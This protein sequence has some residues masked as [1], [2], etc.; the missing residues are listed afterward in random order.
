MATRIEEATRAG[1]ARSRSKLLALLV[2]AGAQLM[3]VLDATIVNVALPHMQEG[4]GFT[5]TGLAWVI[6]AYTLTFGGL[7]LLGGRAGDVLGRRRVFIA[8]ILLFAGA[9]LAGG[10]ATSQAW[11]IVCRAAQGVGAAMA[12]PTALA[13]IT[14]TFA[15]GPE[16]N[17]AFGIYAAVAGAGA[18]IG[19]ILGGVLTDLLSWRWVLFVNVPIG[20]L[21]AVAAPY[22]L[23]ESERVA[24]RF[25]LPGALTATLGVSALVYGFIHSAEAGWGATGTVTAFVAAAVL[26]FSFVAIELRSSAPLVPMRL[27]ANRDRW[28]SYAIMLAVASSMFG[29]FFY[30][31]Q[32]V[33]EILGYSP[34]KAGLAFLP[35]SAAIIVAAQIASRLIARV[36]PRKLIAT[37]AVLTLVGLLWLSRINVDSGYLT[38]LLPAFIVQATGMGLMFVPVTLTAVSGVPRHE[39]GVASAMLNVSQQVGGAVG[40]SV[41]VTISA[42]ATRSAMASG[43]AHGAVGSAAEKAQLV[44][45]SL[46]HGWGEGILL[47]AVF[48]AVALAVALLALRPGGQ[49]NPDQNLGREVPDD[50]SDLERVPAMD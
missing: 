25:D 49:A 27:F 39:T 11:L 15:E 22:A 43:L 36:G 3:V 5:R 37:G 31:T 38:F 10:L 32:F 21:L 1:S 12:A 8:G 23:S 40:L 4:L 13:L 7:L 44:A 47:A 46:V 6:D 2:I 14:T 42:T 18:A 16:R 24:G 50:T 34:L 33:Q 17:R 35:F 26:L 41:L 19:L 45:T 28:A 9:S 30:M 48:A 29:V 20:V